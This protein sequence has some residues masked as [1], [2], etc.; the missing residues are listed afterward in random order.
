MIVYSTLQNDMNTVAHLC[1]RGVRA[2]EM[3]AEKKKFISTFFISVSTVVSERLGSGEKLL[4]FVDVLALM[5]LSL[6]LEGSGWK[7]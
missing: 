3:E 5:A 4:V 6:L 1:C 2:T 7:R